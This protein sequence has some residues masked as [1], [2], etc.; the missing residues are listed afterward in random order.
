M[1]QFTLRKTVIS[2]EN[3]RK[4]VIFVPKGSL[5][6]IVKNYIRLA[7]LDI[8][9]LSIFSIKANKTKTHLHRQVSFCIVQLD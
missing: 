7:T 6:I 2:F 8:V 5:R 1:F 9:V 4:V 3:R